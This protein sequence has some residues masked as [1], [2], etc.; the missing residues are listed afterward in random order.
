MNIDVTRGISRLC[1]ASCARQPVPYICAASK[2]AS[3]SWQLCMVYLF[4]QD[5]QHAMDWAAT[6]IWRRYIMPCELGDMLIGWS[7]VF[8]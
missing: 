7:M 4:E 3:V 6:Y 5:V 8:P 2:L 1:V